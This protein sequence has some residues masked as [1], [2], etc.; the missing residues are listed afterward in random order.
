MEALVL[1]GLFFILIFL[2]VPIGFAIGI[3]TVGSLFLFT[4]IPFAM[5]AQNAV[6]GVDSF[7]LMAIPF[8]ILAGNIMSTG[9]IAKRI[10]DTANIAFG[11]YTGGLGAVTIVACMFFAALSGSAMAT[12]SAIGAFMIPGMVEKGYNR[13]YSAAL[14]AAAGTIGVIIPPSIPFVLYGVAVGASV[15]DLFV[16]GFLPGFLMGL[17]LIIANYIMSKKFGYKGEEISMTTKEKFSAF[18]DAIPALLTPVIILGGIYIGVFTPTEAAA[19][20]CVYSIIISLFYYKECSIRDLYASFVDSMNTNGLTCFMV[21]LSTVFATYL[22][23]RQIPTMVA[24]AMLGFTSNKIVLLLIINIFLLIVGSFIDNIPATII[25]APILLPIVTGVGMSP[26]TFGIVLT[27]NLAIGFCT[28]PY[29]INLFVGAAVA[30]IRMQDMFRYITWFIFA[31][32]VVLMITTYVGP[33][34]TIFLR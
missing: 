23:M 4:E 1:F 5:V 14:T 34:T 17:S 2:T 19:V 7:P 8:F 30:K 18:L 16:A 6:T 32:L 25:L 28:P 26:T 27:M 20:A 13:A 31:L 11:K 22:S 33:V 3:A 29:G 15:S 9:G 12:V 24:S 21:G 10:V